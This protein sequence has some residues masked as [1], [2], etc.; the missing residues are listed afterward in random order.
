MRSRI[1]CVFLS[2]SLLALAACGSAPKETIAP[3]PV[4]T[5]ASTPSGPPPLSLYFSALAPNLAP[6]STPAPTPLSTV[7][8]LD[9][10]TGKVRWTY[11]AGAQVQN[12]PV[13]A[14]DTL[15]VG[16]DNQTVYA[17]NASDGSVRWKANIG[18]EPHVITVQDGVV[19]GDIDQNNGGHTTRGPIFALNAGNGSLKWQ[20]DISGSFYGL[21]NNI[22][23]VT[24]ASNQLYALNAANGSVRWQFQMTAPFDGLKVAQGQVYLLAAQR[25]SGTPNVV[26]YVLNAGTGALDWRYPTSEKTLK[27]LS[28]V[29]ADNGALYLISS[30]QNLGALPLALA[31]NANDGSVLWQYQTNSDAASFTSAALDAGVLYLGTDTGLLIALR[32]QDGTKRWQTNVADTT[33]NIDLMSQGVMYLTVSGEGVTALKTGTGAV[34]WR[35]RSANYVSISSAKDGVLYGFSLSGALNAT[36]HNY[37]LALKASSGTL[38][39]RYDAGASSIYPV[40]N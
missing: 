11:T 30:E 14:Q 32:A 40:L 27:N 7:S 10:G 23:Y 37:I 24:T 2:L 29:G 13:V 6:A 31:L 19:Y 36:S 17:L 20:S 22:I 38:L 16:A 25:A 26:L 18:G 3:T 8:A 33:M 1:A 39:W 15:F 9:A 34:L 12:V 5:R 28:L 21:V 35:Y 4:P